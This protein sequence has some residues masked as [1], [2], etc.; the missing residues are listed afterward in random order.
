MIQFEEGLAHD[1]KYLNRQV[2]EYLH[3]QTFTVEQEQAIIKL[4]TAIASGYNH[5]ISRMKWGPGWD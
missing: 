4:I 3:G 2:S 1:A 5:T